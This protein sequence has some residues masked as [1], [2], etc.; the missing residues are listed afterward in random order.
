MKEHLDLEF[1]RG[2]SLLLNSTSLVAMA[3]SPQSMIVLMNGFVSVNWEPPL[4]E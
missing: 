1:E 2:A 3:E 4:R